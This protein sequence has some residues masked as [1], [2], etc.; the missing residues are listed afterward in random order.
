MTR[1]PTAR[2]L[3]LIGPGLL[4]AATGVGAGDLATAGFSGSRLGLAICWAV[5]VGA[6]LKFVVT[7]GVARWQVATGE[8]LLAGLGR[9][10][11]PI[12]GIVFLL[13]AAPWLV[14]TGGALISACAA[15]TLALLGVEAT[16]TLRALAGGACSTLGVLV[17]LRGGYKLFER[18][19]AVCVG[20]MFLVV[21]VS[22]GATR[23]DLG[24]LAR[25]LLVP[26]IPPVEG[27]LPWTVALIG[28]VGGTLTILCY[29]AW[30]R[31]HA[32]A[33]GHTPDAR[34]AL[35]C[36]RIDLALGYA[37]TA[38]FGVAMVVIASGVG[39]EGRGSGLIVAL[40]D[41]LG[42]GV[43][44]WAR[45]AFI[46]GAWAAVLSSL[47]GVWQAFPM[48][49]SD[50]VRASGLLGTDA[51]RAHPAGSTGKDP[52]AIATLLCIA[53]LPMLTLVLDFATIQRAYGVYGA[54][55]VPLL[56]LTLLIT[57]RRTAW[58][59]EHRNGPI[60]SIALV[61]TL[62]FFAYL[63]LP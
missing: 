8:T 60:A 21:I 19:M 38:V 13:Y 43:G 31:D 9:R 27:A 22:A 58:L 11:G 16:T 48:L 57:N 20:L 41:R 39:A 24:E 45:L 23:P 59:G 29:G 50:A 35:R 26:R 3:A 40:A 56:A 61:L 37:V 32:A 2:K 34:T 54:T 42:E 12:A 52:V 53:T 63:A 49:V 33:G 10:I 36:A 1:Q 17:A 55:F 51:R 14:I 44:P 6:L 5:V 18:I 15:T 7:E 30:M 25:G 46:A 62:A 47:L 4:V 28:G